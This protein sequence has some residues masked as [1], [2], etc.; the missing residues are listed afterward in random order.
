MMVD[1]PLT[2]ALSPILPIAILLPFLLLKLNR[3][4]KAWMVLIPFA[5]VVALMAG[6]QFLPVRGI[7]DAFAY[8]YPFI[9]SLAGSLCILILMAGVFPST[10]S[11]ARFLVLPALFILPGLAVL[12]SCKE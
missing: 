12:L 4:A 3:R 6:G 2:R 9:V 10:S 7:A 11:I 8:M 1:W 5:V